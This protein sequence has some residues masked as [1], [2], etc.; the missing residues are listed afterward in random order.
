MRLSHAG[1]SKMKILWP[2]EASGDQRLPNASAANTHTLLHL[3][4]RESHDHG[5]PARP[6]RPG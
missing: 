1:R 2:P 3:L 4:L 5:D 6:T